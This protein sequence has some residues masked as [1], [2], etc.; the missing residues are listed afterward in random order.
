VSPRAAKPQDDDADA[1]HRVLARAAAAW[2]N[3]AE[4]MHDAPSEWSSAFRASAISHRA[5]A[6]GTA[7]LWRIAWR[8]ANAPSSLVVKR[9]AP[10]EGAGAR[11]QATS[12]PADPFYWARE[13]LAYEA[14]FF[15]GERTGIR[16]AQ[17]YFVDRHDDVIDLYLEDVAG[18]PGSGWAIDAYALAAERLGRFQ[19][20]ATALPADA[21]WMSGPGFF[22]AYIARRDDLYAEAEAAMRAPTPYLEGEGLR[23]LGPAVRRLWERRERALAFCA[24]LPLTRCHNDFWSPNLFALRRRAQTVAIDLAYAGLGPPGHD[25]ANLAADAVMDFFVPAADAQRLWDAVAAGYGRGLSTGLA[26]EAVRTAEQVMELTAALKFAWLIPATFRV[27]GT[28]AGVAT[29]A[30]QHGDP[31]EFFRKRSAALRFI[32]TLVERSLCMLDAI[33]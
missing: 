25:P 11:W 5:V 16:S 9:L 19:A 24:T 12:D 10:S 22:A 23:E 30:E 32:G 3:I 8:G 17:C 15:G 31:G 4:N 14:R 28:P 7:G 1:S 33:G 21:P 13:A 6:S 26:G 2:K 29:I 18:E 20:A 27:A